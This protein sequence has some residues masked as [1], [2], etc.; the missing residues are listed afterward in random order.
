MDVVPLATDSVSSGLSG[1]GVVW[2]APD[3]EARI[4]L[5]EAANADL[6]HAQ[7]VRQFASYRG[8]R[9]FPGWYWS[10][11]TGGHVPYESWLERDHALLLDFD[12][13]V[14]GLAAHLSGCNGKRTRRGASA[15]MCQISLPEPWTVSA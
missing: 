5:A 3:G 4:S 7:P 9:H 14:V 8:Q 11:T 10:A 1:F 15:G 2:N 13:R 6:E 12:Q